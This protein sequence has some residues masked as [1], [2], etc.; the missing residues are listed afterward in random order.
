MVE[1]KRARI[2][3]RST[4]PIATAR[5]KRC[6]STGWIGTS[7]AATK[8]PSTS[9]P[10][11][12][13][14]IDRTPAR[15]RTS[16]ARA[17]RMAERQRQADELLADQPRPC[18][19]GARPAAARHLLTEAVASDRR[20]RACLGPAL[21][22]E[23]VER[24]HAGTASLRPPPRRGPTPGRPR[25]VLAAAFARA[26]QP[27]LLVLA[28]VVA[29]GIAHAGGAAVAGARGRPPEVSASGRRAGEA[30]GALELGGR[31]RARP[32]VVRSRAV[33]R[34]A[35][36]ARS[37]GRRQPRAIR[38]RCPPDGD[39]TTVACQQP[40]LFGAVGG[41]TQTMRCPKCHY[42][43]FEPEPRCRNCGY[44]LAVEEADLVIKAAEPIAAPLADLSLRSRCRP[45]G[46]A[47]RAASR[48]GSI[49][50]L[51]RRPAA[52]AAWRWLTNPCRYQRLRRRCARQRPLIVRRR[53][54]ERRSRHVRLRDA[55]LVAPSPPARVPAATA[56]RR[57]RDR[58]AAAV[59][60]GDACRTLTSRRS[61]RLPSQT[62]RS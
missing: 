45:D 1:P 55:G 60:Q 20:G 54:R 28:A 3:S 25:L 39:S 58:G 32:D 2:G 34:S 24:A 17:R 22:L 8:T 42:L 51:A 30:A 19:I 50:R 31:A 5:L 12:C 23:R 33:G 52:L 14:S 21:R 10:G 36:G 7:T 46:A 11:C 35:G 49:G 6:S 29:G 15:A 4:L 43:S 27:A 26:G 37:G 44:D 9:G 59:R 57:A 13:F 62:S 61:M 38:R 41:A 48:P 40:R 56:P 16:T 47:S 53:R 18:S